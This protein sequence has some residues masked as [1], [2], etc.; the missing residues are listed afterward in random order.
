MCSKICKNVFQ[1]PSTISNTLKNKML[2]KFYQLIP[3]WVNLNCISQNLQTDD[4]Q[5][6]KT[7]LKT[8]KTSIKIFCR[9]IP[10]ISRMLPKYQVQTTH[11]QLEPTKCPLWL[12]QYA[13]IHMLLKWFMKM[14]FNQICI[15]VICDPTKI[16][17]IH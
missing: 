5:P 15:F 16:E 8:L 9:N 2:P 3:K 4:L 6:T 1:S 13:K 10:T 12:Q 11:Q 14:M 7:Q 17:G